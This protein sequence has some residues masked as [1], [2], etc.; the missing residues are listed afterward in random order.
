MGQDILSV[1][2]PWDGNGVITRLDPLTGTW[3]F[4]ALHDSTLGTPTGGTRIKVYPELSAA[5]IDATRLA[6]G[7]TYKWAGL[8][9]DYGGGKAVLALPEQ[10]LDDN[11][12]QGL[13]KRYGAFIE[14]LSGAFK[15]G[16]DLGASADDMA[17]IASRCQHVLGVDYDTMDSTDPG[18]FT[19]H[20]VEVGLRAALAQVFGSDS[21]ADRTILVQGLGGV[22][23]PLARSLAADGARLI[24]NDLDAHRAETLAEEL[25]CQ[26][27]AS[28][29]LYSTPCDVYAPCAIGATVNAQTIPQLACRI[30]AGSA[31]N[32]L[33]EA[34]DAERLHQRGVL[35]V[36][37]YIINSGGAMA[38]SL[39]HTGLTERDELMRRV[40]GIRPAITEILQEAAASNT[41]P[42]VAARHRVD[43]ILAQRRETI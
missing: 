38:I 30:V 25:S 37:D 9:M 12:R 18:P 26:T 14:S 13:L 16:A 11:A 41:S 43:R 35:Y 19:A 21:P 20:G 15:T 29:S 24:L 22:G 33:L 1:I 42:V 6:E 2:E 31:N 23:A 34:E 17:T 8:G 7:M 39:Q 32:Q 3:I 5:L 36:P 28:D 4:I 27:A 10:P 40:A